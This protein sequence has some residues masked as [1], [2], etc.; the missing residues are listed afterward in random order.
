MLF[1]ILDL[2]RWPAIL[3]FIAAGFCAAAL[4]FVSFNL[5]HVAMANAAFLARYGWLAVMEGALWQLATL[6]LTGAFALLCYFGFK[7]CENELV[8]RY[9]VW[10]IRRRSKDSE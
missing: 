8:Q 1:R 4:A 6:V 2:T 5:F 7:L 9:R 3:V 10:T